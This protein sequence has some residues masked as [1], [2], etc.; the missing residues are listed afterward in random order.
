MR[1]IAAAAL[2]GVLV[3][4]VARAGTPAECGAPAAMSDDWPVSPPA[5]QGLDPELICATG[6]GL[7]NR[8]EAAPHG[9]VVVRH[10][11]LVYEQYFTS[12][13]R[14]GYVVPYNAN[15]LH[16]IASI[17]KGV[18]ALLVG[19]AFDRG[20]LSDL[21]APIVSFFPEYADLRTPEKDRITLHHLLAMTSGLDWPERAIS[22]DNWANIV[23]QG[24]SASDPY[25]FVLARPVETRPGTAWNYNSGGVWLLGLILRK[26]SGQPIEE[27]A[28]EALLEPLGIQDE[29]WGR[30]SNGD[31]GTSNGLRLRPRDLAKLGQLVLDGGV[32][33]GRRIVSAGWIKQM[34]APQSPRGWS[35]SFARSYGYLWWQG[36]SLI[37]DHDI[38]WVGALGRGGQR[39]Y[40][41]PTLNLVVAVTA[42]LYIANGGSPAAESLAG[43][44]ALNS[45]VLRAALGH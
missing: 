37:G 18:V 10:G 45:F 9:V 8:T 26:V 21:D 41:V 24:R 39:L 28:K 14:Y 30:F 12:E 29:M 32:W 25:L 44:T 6:P 20:W 43:D 36:Q 1:L 5:Q 4:A 33:H 38:E 27:F 16:D 40:V 2:C 34:I 7:G 19:I 15:T 23:R 13:D 11:A 35:F 42:G 3:A 17:T 22:I 31:A